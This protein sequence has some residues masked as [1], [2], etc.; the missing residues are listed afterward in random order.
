VKKTVSCHRHSNGHAINIM[1]SA[2][3][4]KQQ[5]AVAAA[6]SKFCKDT[7]HTGKTLQVN[8]WHSGASF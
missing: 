7:Q 8:E 5:Q 2:M 6:A 4:C 1:A 3:G